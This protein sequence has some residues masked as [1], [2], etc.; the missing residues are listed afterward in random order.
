MANLYHTLYLLWRLDI[1]VWQV[2]DPSNTH[3]TCDKERVY[4][5]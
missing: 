5:R 1:S 4:S 3:T 2:N